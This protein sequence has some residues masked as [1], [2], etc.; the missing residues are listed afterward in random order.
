MA[1]FQVRVNG[2]SMEIVGGEELLASEWAA[3]VLPAEEY[4]LPTPE[5]FQRTWL[6]SGVTEAE[7]ARGTLSSALLR[8]LLRDLEYDLERR[9]FV[10]MPP[11]PARWA[12]EGPLESRYVMR[13]YYAHSLANRRQEF[14]GT[15]RGEMHMRLDSSP[16]PLKAAQTILDMLLAGRVNGSFYVGADGTAC[17]YGWLYTVEECGGQLPDLAMTRIQQRYGINGITPLE[18]FV[19]QIHSG[20]TPENNN[21]AKALAEALQAYIQERQQR[22]NTERLEAQYDAIAAEL[23]EAE[24]RELEWA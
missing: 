7:P 23:N 6:V 13:Y 4:H 2:H 20:Q 9:T 3:P 15:A 8:E 14:T 21:A 19:S 18:V 11:A 16:E 24:E 17:F 22:E 5:E 1:E 10:S 12:L